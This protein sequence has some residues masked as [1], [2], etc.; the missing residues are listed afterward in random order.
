MRSY[1][2]KTILFQAVQFSLNIQ[3]SFIWPIDMILSGATTSGPSGPVNDG[4]EGALLILQS[5][6]I[7][8]TSQSDFL[9]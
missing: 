3:F 7:T 5:S 1:N 6:S 4:N 9:V 8:K 2:V